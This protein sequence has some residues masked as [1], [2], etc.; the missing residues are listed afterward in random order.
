MPSLAQI[1][2]TVGQGRGLPQRFRPFANQ[3][4]NEAFLRFAP[5]WEGL[6]ALREQSAGTMRQGITQ[7]TSAA[8][9]NAALARQGAKDFGG[10]PANPLPYEGAPGSSA[11]IAATNRGLTR[12]GTLAMLATAANNAPIA[13]AQQVRQLTDVHADDLAKINSQR[14]SL[15]GQVGA[16]V[17]GRLGSL[18]GEDRKS[19][20]AVNEQKR[21]LEN[22]LITSGVN[23]DGSIREGGPKDPALKPDA[24]GPYGYTKKEWLALPLGERQRIRKAAEA[25]K[26]G[27]GGKPIPPGATERRTSLQHGALKDQLSG[28]IAQIQKKAKLGRSRRELADLYLSGRP[29]Q[30]VELKPGDPRYDPANPAKNK[31]TAPKVDKVPQLALSVALDLAF[32]GHV[33]H[34]NVIKL[35]RRGYSIKELGIPTRSRPKSPAGSVNTGFGGSIP[36]PSS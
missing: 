29:A 9:L 31:R 16:F 23:P 2:A 25:K 18:I 4:A 24:P 32:D 30:T 12:E 26:N 27:K 3:A 28:T 13:G 8:Q 21:S 33:S 11:A 6:N 10:L 7:A 36:F 15:G 35:Q 19:R 5:E 1:L 22:Q 17:Q 14:A 34:D 20:A